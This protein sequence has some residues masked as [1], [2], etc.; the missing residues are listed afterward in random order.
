MWINGY[1]QTP[2][3]AEPCPHPDC[4]WSESLSILEILDFCDASEIISFGNQNMRDVNP[5]R[6]CILLIT[7]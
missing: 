2:H 5:Q 4:A 1:S 6:K 3:L 7:L